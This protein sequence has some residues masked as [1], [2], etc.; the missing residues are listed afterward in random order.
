[1][2]MDEGAQI[3]VEGWLN[4]KRRE[5]YHYITDETKLREAE[6]FVRAAESRGAVVKV[7]VLDSRRVQA[8]ETVE[9]MRES[10]ASATVIIGATSHSFITT[11]AVDYALKQGARFLSLPLS[12][13]DG[14]SLMENEL[15]RMEPRQALRQGRPLVKALNAA[16]TIRV[17]TA[18]GTDVTFS[19]KGRKAGILTGRAARPGAFASASFEA[20]VPIV[21]NATNGRV[22]LD[23]S[24][25]YLGLVRQPVELRF[26]DGYLVSIEDSED[27]R[28][29]S[30]YM[31]GFGDREMYCA[32]EFGIG[33][34]AYARCRGVAYIEDESALGTFHIG[35]GRNVSLGGS[36]S[37]AGH[38]DIVVHR[39]TIEADGAVLMREGLFTL[40]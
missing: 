14:S 30:D 9:A 1:M 28:R 11:E 34:N 21:E 12:T 32:A 22:V 6:A 13:N 37:A 38:F 25:G 36:H 39:P 35:F 18:L 17:R 5:M 4:V 24:L 2:T 31:A 3:I 15:F 16:R 33:L 29:L 26:A 19:K 7:T 10:M 8:A 40:S 23:G 27:G 20:Y